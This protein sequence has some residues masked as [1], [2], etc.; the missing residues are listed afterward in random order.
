VFRPTRLADYDWARFDD[1]RKRRVRHNRLKQLD[2]LVF[3]HDALGRTLEKTDQDKGV[4]WHYSYNS[5]N[6]LTQVCVRSRKGFTQVRFSYDALGRRTGRTDGQTQTRFVWDGM[7]LL[8]E[9]RGGATSTY[10]YEQDSY[11]PLARLE[12]DGSIC[13]FHCD[14]SGR[15]EEMTDARGNNVWRARYSV[16]GRLLFEN[17]TAFA[18]RG[19]EQNL[20]MQGQYEDRDTGLCYNTFR[21]YDA[22]IGRFQGAE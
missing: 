2:G 6:Q 8:Q 20:R 16:W 21:Y 15:P 18:P 9:E 19:F 13:H 7:K 5:E 10:L 14:A 1:H 4:T 17:V 12:Q 11:T 22:D 3:R